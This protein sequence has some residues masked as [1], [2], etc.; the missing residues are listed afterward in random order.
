[1]AAPEDELEF[2]LRSGNRTELLLAL[3]E[4]QPLDRYDL[5]GRLDA[6]RRTVTRAL[7]A[8]RDRGYIREAEAGYSLTAFGA[9]VAESYRESRRRVG[10]ATEYRPLL[11]HLDTRGLDLNLDLELLEGAD[12][13]VASE[14]SPFVVLNRTLELREGASRIRELAPG[15]EKR[16][17][18]QLAGRLRN[19]EDLEMEVILPP[20]AVETVRETEAFADGHAVAR[21]TDAIEFYVAPEPF[22]V[23]VGVMDDTAVLGAGEGG[24]PLAMAESD[25]PAFREWAEARLDE[26]RDA[27]TP[28]TAD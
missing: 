16:S 12:L 4:A 5:E 2:L 27:A 22:S 15:I 24:E 28:L 3:A 17:V 19:G 9:S 10:L 6:S 18:E 26:F 1:M 13:T 11:E 23:F 14:T 21:E 25:R 8:L 20:E 7:D